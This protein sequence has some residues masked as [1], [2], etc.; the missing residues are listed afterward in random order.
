MLRDVVMNGKLL[1]RDFNYAER[2]VSLQSLGNRQLL[3]ILQKV[4]LASIETSHREIQYYAPAIR[5]VLL[6]PEN[7]YLIS[8]TEP[9]IDDGQEHGWD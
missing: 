4:F 5:I 6:Q 1:A 8:N 3:T 7:N 2:F 9:I